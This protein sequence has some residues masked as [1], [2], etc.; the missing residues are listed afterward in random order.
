MNADKQTVHEVKK[1]YP[2][3]EIIEVQQIERNNIMLTTEELDYMLRV[4][5]A[6]KEGKEIEYRCKNYNSC[7]LENKR[8]TY[9]ENPCFDFA[10]SVYRV[11]VKPEEPK[12]RPWLI[13][14]VPIGALIRWIDHTQPSRVFDVTMITGITS[15]WVMTPIDE[16]TTPVMLECFE[17]SLDQGKSWQPCG[18]S[19]S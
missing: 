5:E 6:Y 15:S 10:H 11:K 7:L 2:K 17:Y 4:I 1:F 13:G 3:V 19:I 12:Y 9:V 18:V 16:F 14:E 8:W